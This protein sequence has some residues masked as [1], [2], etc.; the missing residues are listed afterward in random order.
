MGWQLARGP[1][2]NNVKSAVPGIRVAL[3]RESVSP[4]TM[5]AVTRRDEDEALAERCE[6]LE[7][8]IGEARL[9]TGIVKW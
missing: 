6:E 5:R 8:K 7:A 2:S 1:H 3:A 4:W 9:K